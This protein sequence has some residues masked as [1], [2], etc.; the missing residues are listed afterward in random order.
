P[1]SRASAPARTR[2]TS[3]RPSPSSGPAPP[4]LLR[5]WRRRSAC[6]PPGR[7]R[8]PAEEGRSREVKPAP[9]PPSLSGRHD[10]AF[11]PRLDG[12]VEAAPG[13]VD[14]RAVTGEVRAIGHDQGRSI[15]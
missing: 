1:G 5:T 8:A 10:E 4:A 2:A 11:R 9:R 7:P 6:P 12:E 15:V 14:A 13:T 3:A